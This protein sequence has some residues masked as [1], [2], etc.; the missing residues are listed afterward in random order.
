MSKLMDIIMSKVG[1]FT[2]VIS[3]F[4][5]LVIACS[6]SNPTTP[7]NQLNDTPVPSTN[8]APKR[9]GW[10]PSE[11]CGYLSDITGLETR[12]YKVDYD[13]VYGCSSAYKEL[14]TGNPLANNIAYYVKGDANTATELRVVLNVFFAAQ[15]T[16]AAHQSLMVAG[17][18]LTK[19]AA[20]L[21]LPNDVSNAILSGETGKWTVENFTLEITRDDWATGKGYE[22]HYILG[23][24]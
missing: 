2:F 6:N 21:R 1:T 23:K 12:G 16:K 14:G 10:N 5:T 19:K 8:A 17:V 24:N 4:F 3:S 9:K 22:I 11:A 18:D 13:D 7:S 20:E 15:K